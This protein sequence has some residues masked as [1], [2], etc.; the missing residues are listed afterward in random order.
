MVAENGYESP[1]IEEG[2]RPPLPR[3]RRM[4]VTGIL[5]PSTTTV[6]TNA[7]Q[8]ECGDNGLTGVMMRDVAARKA[9]RKVGIR[10]R[11]CCFKWTWFTMTMVCYQEDR[12]IS[13][14]NSMLT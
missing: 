14:G 5:T 3:Q 10:D 6:N 7:A 1:G 4:T 13:K 11:I 2:L 9:N 12:L 8:L